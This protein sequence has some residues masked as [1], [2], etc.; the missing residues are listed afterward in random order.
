ME[1]T[2]WYKDAVI[3]QIYPRS[4]KDSND[5]GIGDI[6][7]II[8]KV[9]YLKKLGVNCIWLSPI[10]DSPQED[11]GYDISDYYSIYKPF[12]NIDDLKQLI[13]VLHKNDIRIIMDL[14][15][16]HTSFKHEWFKKAYEDENSKYRNY[17]YFKK[18]KGKK[19][20]KRPNN[21]TGFFGESTWTR[22][23]NSPY[24]YLHLFA[25]GQPDLNWENKEVREEVKKILRYYLDMGID[26]FRCDVIT[27]ISKKQDFKSRFPKVALT[28]KDA[29]VNGPRLHE[30][31]HELY[32]DVYKDYDCMTV[33]ETVLSNV[34]EAKELVIP[35]REELSM[36][37]N[38]DHTN[39]DNYFGIKW[40]ERKFKLKRFKKVYARWQKAMYECKG[41]NSL[42]IENHDQR[43][44]TGRFNTSLDPKYKDLSSKMLA[45][46]YF[47]MQ[48]T[49]FIYQGQELGMTNADLKTYDDFEDVESKNMVT[50]MKNNIFVRPILKK[51][52]FRQSR[53]NARTPMQWDKSQYAG[54]SSVKP[55]MKVNGNKNYINA[56]D[57]I[58]EP[59]SLFN[60]YQKL[61][62]IRKEESI[63]KDGKYIDLNSK[64]TKVFAYKRSTGN[65]EIIII[66][67]FTNKV[68]N[69]KLL[70]KYKDYDVILSNYED[71]DDINLRPYETMVLKKEKQNE[72][73]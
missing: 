10:Y 25:K 14:V 40:I 44:S 43:R 59:S 46:T 22:V 32:T 69:E 13:E 21:W 41:W 57:E 72:H 64:S 70:S 12:G 6:Q 34:K 31:L 20:N 8:S 62:N 15:V 67:N 53:D 66:S 49:P 65:D 35:D 45:T 33:G 28:G 73:N 16:N 63:I 23:D 50:L 27:L 17:Y 29:F 55:W 68:V 58:N 51:S 39:V 30:F 36:V 5:D 37:F 71:R 52:L 38:F 48:G 60:Y 24:Y 42:F 26:G 7:G 1:H 47:L 9:D 56:E 19:Y 3:Y 54:F 11:N 61:I 4:F 18:G 2:N